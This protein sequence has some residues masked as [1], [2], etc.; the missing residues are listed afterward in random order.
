VG[1]PPLEKDTIRS[2]LSRLAYYKYLLPVTAFAS[3]ALLF[4]KGAAS[5]FCPNSAQILPLLLLL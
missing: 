4:L 3:I 5:K 1:A 2:I